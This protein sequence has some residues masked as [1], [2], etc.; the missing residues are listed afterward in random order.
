M[1]SVPEPVSFEE[2]KRVL[3]ARRTFVEKNA[4]RYMNDLIEIGEEYQRLLQLHGHQQGPDVMKSG[5]KEHKAL[6]SS[7]ATSI[8]KLFLHGYRHEYDSSDSSPSTTPTGS[9]RRRLDGQGHH[10]AN[11][12]LPFPSVTLEGTYPFVDDM[13]AGDE[14]IDELTATSGLPPAAV[15][16]LQSRR[17][18]VQKYQL[19]AAVAQRKARLWKERNHSSQKQVLEASL[20]EE[21]T[22]FRQHHMLLGKDL[23]R[24]AHEYYQEHVAKV[25]VPVAMK[26]MHHESWPPPVA[27]VATTSHDALSVPPSL[28][29]FDTTPKASFEATI[30][31]SPLPPPPTAATEDRDIQEEHERR[32]GVEEGLPDRPEDLQDE[33]KRRVFLAVLAAV[34]NVINN[35]FG[36]LPKLRTDS[37]WKDSRRLRRIRILATPLT[38]ALQFLISVAEE[39]T[40]RKLATNTGERKYFL[41]AGFSS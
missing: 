10:L 31:P 24:S 30:V 15:S 29:S 33:E 1:Q 37:A 25:T 18:Q 39:V 6:A 9:K 40:E 14:D 4:L 27:V 20:K 22:D 3:L 23:L 19:V 12:T 32:G 34:C 41:S 21:F 26:A 8:D 36:P 17:E 35:S 16:I 28:S 11:S 13:D 38:L 2:A 7:I 5:S